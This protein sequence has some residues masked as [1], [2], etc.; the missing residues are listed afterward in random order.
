MPKRKRQPLFWVHLATDTLLS[1]R[2]QD[3]ITG[4]P[5]SESM[6]TDCAAYWAK[7]PAITGMTLNTG[8]RPEW[9]TDHE[10]QA[11]FITAR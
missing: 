9:P 6:E 10:T 4:G 8:L 3:K 5:D 7:S 11:A 1:A 2:T